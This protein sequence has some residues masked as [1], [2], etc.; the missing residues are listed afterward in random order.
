MTPKEKVTSFIKRN[1]E[2]EE[3]KWACG[4]ANN[5]LAWSDVWDVWRSK[6]ATKSDDSDEITLL[7][8]YLKECKR[9]DDFNEWRKKQ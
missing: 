7:R 3:S 8:K 4:M 2:T 6:T 1:C 5:Y 9:M